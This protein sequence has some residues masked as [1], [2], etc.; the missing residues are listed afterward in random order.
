MSVT[1]AT[2]FEKIGAH[3]GDVMRAH[4]DLAGAHRVEVAQPADHARRALDLA[5]R[6]RR[7]AQLVALLRARPLLEALRA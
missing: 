2:I 1:V 4:E 3:A 7:A 6:R 5:R